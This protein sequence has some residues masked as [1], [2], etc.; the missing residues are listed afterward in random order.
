MSKCLE[1]PWQSCQQAGM[2]AKSKQCSDDTD[3]VLNQAWME[4][5]SWMIKLTWFAIHC[6][7][8]NDIL[9][10]ASALLWLCLNPGSKILCAGPSWPTATQQ[11]CSYRLVQRCLGLG[12]KKEVLSRQ[13]WNM[14]TINGHR[15]HQP[16]LLH[17]F[18]QM[19]SGPCLLLE[20][21]QAPCQDGLEVRLWPKK[22]A[23][24]RSGT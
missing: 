16:S 23:S 17:H 3:G 18:M 2:Q 14:A 12:L 8:C 24:K 1:R 11:I 9:S 21:L 10:I 4:S 19:Q 15:V 7:S 13:T 5:N 22:S 6:P 20:P